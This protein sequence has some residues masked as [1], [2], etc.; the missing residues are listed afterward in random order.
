MA[1]KS[2]TNGRQ[3][4]Q[5]LRPLGVSIIS[6]LGMIVSVL[7]VLAGILFTAVMPVAGMIGLFG[8]ILRFFSGVNCVVFLKIFIIRIFSS[9]KPRKKEK[10]RL[11]FIKALEII[12]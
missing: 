8:N 5:S 6:V 9:F 11:K 7:I 3:G 12:S 10:I 1:K 2:K 4:R